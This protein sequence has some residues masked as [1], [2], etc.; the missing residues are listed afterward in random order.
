M[1]YYEI[2]EVSPQASKE[3]LRAAY[4]S[5]MQR[6]HPD[7]HPHDAD[8]AHRAALIAQAY[9]VLSDADKRAA[10]DT[11]LARTQDETPLARPHAAAPRVGRVVAPV[12]PANWYVWLLGGVILVSSMVVFLLSREKPGPRVVGQLSPA[13]QQP[14][15]KPSTIGTLKFPLLTS[16]LHVVLPRRASSP[17][18]TEAG[19]YTLTIPAL[20]VEI[21]SMES[22]Q[23]ARTLDVQKEMVLLK[24]TEKLA[25]ADY[26][27][28]RM[29]S[30]GEKYLK[31][32]IY[33]AL[34]DI[35]GTM[36]MDDSGGNQR[37]GV[38]AVVLPESFDIR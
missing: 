38:T 5:L 31:L 9:A 33:E 37:Y 8:P 34:R 15:Q 32:Y 19:P 26:A 24:L 11:L 7:R 10:Y 1:N 20:T 14:A 16:S 23:F 25:R 28:L 17:D 4:K 6:H 36:G 12:S 21:G 13:S 35:T 2:L 29:A 18:N 27:E 22:E 3:V 30:E